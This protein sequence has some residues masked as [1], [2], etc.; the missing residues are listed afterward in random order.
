MPFSYEHCTAQYILDNLKGE[1][2]KRESEH[3]T[4]CDTLLTVKEEPGTADVSEVP[5]ASSEPDASE[6]LQSEPQVPKEVTELIEKLLQVDGNEKDSEGI[7]SVLW[8]FGGQSVYYVTHSVFLTV[9]AIYFLVYNLSWGPDEV[10][11]R[12]VKQGVFRTVQD[13]FCDRTN[14]DYL[15]IWMSSVSGLVSQ[16]EVTQEAAT[17]EMLSERLPP[18]FLVCTHADEPYKGK[19][20]EE[21]ARELFTSLKAKSYGKH[22]LDYFCVDNTKSGGGEECPSVTRLRKVVLDVV[23]QLP[24]MK[25]VLPIK[26]LKYEKALQGMLQDDWKWISRDE[27]WRIAHEECGI[28]N[29][30]QFEALLTFLH[31]QRTLIHFGDTRELRKI[32]ILDPQWLIDIFKKII[33]IKPTERKGRKFEE[34]WL[35]LETTGILDERLLQHVWGPLFD[36]EETSSSLVALMEKFCLLCPWPSSAT[37]KALNEYLVPS[38]LLFPP[39]EDIISSLHLQAFHLFL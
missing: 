38:M 7:Y 28:S 10:A 14:R 13:G 1:R 22:L 25:E 20:P 30:E 11:K 16:D 24:Q 37:S 33:A 6:T 31:D 34:L 36:N 12:Q 23:K 26:W 21:I 5:V 8:D 17:C 27:A 9:R 39:K 35:K 2:Q 15:N 32:V 3:L 29:E 4:V 18:V 19:D